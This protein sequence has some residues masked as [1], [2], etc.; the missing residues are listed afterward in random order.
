[1][2]IHS[3]RTCHSDLLDLKGKLDL[4]LKKLQDLKLRVEV[5]ENKNESSRDD[6]RIEQKKTPIDV[7][8]TKIT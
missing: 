6:T 1:M 3:G 5:L 8:M 2:L 4:I 7:G